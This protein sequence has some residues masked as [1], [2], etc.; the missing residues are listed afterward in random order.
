[1]RDIDSRAALDGVGSLSSGL[2]ASVAQPRFAALL[3]ALFAGLGLAVAATGLYGV[4]SYSVTERRREIG[5]RAAL[6]ATR[7]KL[8]S[9]VLRQGLAFTIAGL[10]LGLI[11][12][13]GASQFL[14]SLLFGVTP[15]DTVAYA[16]APA[17]LIVVALAA[18]LV[19]AWRAAAVDPA[20]ALRAE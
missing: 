5:V 4:L 2:S 19:P 15:Y 9:L 1:V 14:S 3:L 17:V 7:G 20:E 10:A 16:I 13:A 18:C 6:G 8:I 11:A 12:A